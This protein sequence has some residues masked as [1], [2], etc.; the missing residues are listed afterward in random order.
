MDDR[1]DSVYQSLVRCI[2]KHNMLEANEPVIACVSGGC[3]STA[4]LFL[5]NRYGREHG[6]PLLCA[7]FNHML[8]GRNLTGILCSCGTC[9]AGWKFRFMR[10]RKM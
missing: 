4:M 6:H 3:D 8:R 1:T 2:E 7:H 10:S 9:A 5:L